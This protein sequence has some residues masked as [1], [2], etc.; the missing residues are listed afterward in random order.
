MALIE[1]RRKISLRLTVLQYGI[2]VV[3]SVLIVGFWVL[4][5]VQHAKYAEIAENNHQRTLALRAPRGLVFDRDGRVL[6]ENRH[7][8]G[9]SIVREHTKDINRTSAC[10]RRCSASRRGGPR[11]RRPAPPRADLPADHDR[12][13]RVAGAGRRGDRT[14]LRAAG[15]ARREGADAP[16]SG[17]DGV[18]SIRVRRRSQRQP[19]DRRRQPEERRHRRT[20]R[21]RKDLQRDA[22]GRR[23]RAARR[24]QQRR[25]GDP[26]TR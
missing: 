16:L 15:R 3:F 6:V 22:D 10:W 2:T 7:S 11:D 25:A 9:I 21:H 13:G 8:Y 20:I 12:A 24:R 5:V 19:G 23:R 26:D 14:A 1:D 18:P 4:Q 17:A